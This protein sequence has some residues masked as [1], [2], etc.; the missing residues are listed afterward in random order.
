MISHHVGLCVTTTIHPTIV[1][2]LFLDLEV[3]YYEWGVVHYFDDDF[4]IRPNP[5]KIHLII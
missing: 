1:V 2:D 4:S 5:T 3:G